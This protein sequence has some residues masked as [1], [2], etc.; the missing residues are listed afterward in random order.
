MAEVLKKFREEWTKFKRQKKAIADTIAKYKSYPKKLEEA[1][2]VDSVVPTED[3]EPYTD[4][5]TAEFAVE[6]SE[7]LGISMEEA[8]NVAKG[9]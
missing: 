2:K 7:K 6:L 8:M 4:E 5:E 1:L 3:E 9:K